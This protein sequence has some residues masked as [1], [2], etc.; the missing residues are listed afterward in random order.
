M[1][2]PDSLAAIDFDDVE[3]T[4]F[5]EGYQYLAREI[6]EQKAGADLPPSDVVYPS[7]PIGDEWAEEDLP[8]VCPKLWAKYD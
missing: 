5:F 4:L 6:Y 3:E 8:K 7:D 1:A 2:D